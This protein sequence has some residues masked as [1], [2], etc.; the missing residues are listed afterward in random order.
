MAL[1]PFDPQ[2]ADRQ[3]A[4]TRRV[5]E[6]SGT[7]NALPPSIRN[8]Y[9]DYMTRR[10]ERGAPV[11]S[12]TESRLALQAAATGQAATPEPERDP[13]NLLGNTLANARDLASVV[14][15]LFMPTRG[16]PLY[17]EAHETFTEGPQAVGEALDQPNPFKA[18]TDLAAAPGVRLVPGAYV[19]SNLDDPAEL[20]R[21]P[22]FTALDVAPYAKRAAQATP[23][24]KAATAAYRDSLPAT[25][26]AAR[27][28]TVRALEGTGTDPAV[29]GMTPPPVFRTALTRK[30]TPTGEVVPNM[31]GRAAGRVGER[32]AE[33]G[34]GQAAAR[35]FGVGQA[36][37]A[38]RQLAG[39]ASRLDLD[40]TRLASLDPDSIARLSASTDPVQARLGGLL[41]EQRRLYDD[42]AETRGADAATLEAFQDRI[43]RGDL[44]GLTP[45]EQALASRINNLNDTY[46]SF[47]A[48]QFPERV[49]NVTDSRSLFTAPGTEALTGELLDMGKYQRVAR[50]DRKWRAAAL[51]EGELGHNLAHA[52]RAVLDDKN[53]YDIV[54]DADGNK[55]LSVT[56]TA[57]SS[58]NEV[59][60]H[61]AQLA[62]ELPGRVTKP[63]AQAY[64]DMRAFVKARDAFARAKNPEAMG[65][66]VRDMDRTLKAMRRRRGVIGGRVD[67]L[68][69]DGLAQLREARSA[70]DQARKIGTPAKAA[71]R[72]ASAE[73]RVAKEV[74]RAMP[75]RYQPVVRDQFQSE[76]VQRMERAATTD[77]DAAAGLQAARE[78]VFSGLGRWIDESTLDDLWSDLE[79]GWVELKEAGVDP[80]FVHAADDQALAALKFP[81]VAP[82]MSDPGQVRARTWDA[83]PTPGGPFVALSHQ[84]MELV[85][86]LGQ[87]ELTDTIES[88]FARKYGEQLAE[89]TARFEARGAA[90]PAQAARAWMEKHTVAWTPHGVGGR[91]AASVGDTAQL[92]VP[93]SMAQVIR[94]M[95]EPPAESLRRLADP[96]MKVFR[97]AVLPLSPRW[98][99]N[100]VLG[101]SL[102]FT[103]SEGLKGWSTLPRAMREV[104]KF[105]QTVKR[106]WHGDDAPLA[107]TVPRGAPQTRGG[108]SGFQFPE[109][110]A[111]EPATS[112]NRLVATRKH[113]GGRTL[114]HLWDQIQQ[115]KARAGR[116]PIDALY[117][118]NQWVDDIGRTM[119]SIHNYDRAVKAGRGAAE[120]ELEAAAAVRRVS[121]SWDTLLPAERQILRT[122]FPFYSFGRF[123]VGFSLRYPVDH[124][125]RAA[126]TAS[127]ARNEIEDMGTGLPDQFAGLFQLTDMDDQ[128]NAT[129]LAP[130]A[131][132]PFRDVTDWF[133]LQGFVGMTNPLVSATLQALGVEPVQ[134][135]PMLYP[136]MVYDPETGG[137]RAETPGF[138]ESLVASTVPQTQVVRNLILGN[139]EWSDLVQSNPQAAQRQLLSQLGVPTLVQDRNVPQE[140][141]RAEVNRYRS[142]RDEWNEAVRSGGTAGFAE[143][144]PVLAEYVRQYETL[145]AAAAAA[146]Q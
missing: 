23:A 142:M 34:V 76:V 144:Y 106:A 33:T 104:G 5:S 87:R 127:F 145:N 31:L 98:Q 21:N 134:G 64:T 20:A 49:V 1:P 53:V 45:D 14:P 51:A 116:H 15:K 130:G 52:R 9:L 110:L 37:R 93:S 16:N 73:R 30:T 54:R 126:V 78:G 79:R 77:P 141:F 43:V 108:M 143:R 102:I 4:A 135:G 121:Q 26:D 41:D 91:R 109:R 56:P 97:T 44:D 81:H 140:T 36:G 39:L 65:A 71:K 74:E 133:T 59:A 60:D 63:Q 50:A 115:A 8:S 11:L 38:N 138:V 67:D 89:M 100:N 139:E 57:R 83:T 18:L 19:V 55:T 17:K 13:K 62:D 114:A 72:L 40:V 58:I 119:A 69:A 68:V 92:R 10:A 29:L 90:D 85:R 137:L 112:T 28:S 101:N 124:P 24:V 22:L 111:A 95:T 6:L 82:K 66:A 12:N 132:N 146:Q 131:A 120:A 105:S 103:A 107:S 88:V 96:V 80:V 125:V 61:F 118:A 117:A 35:T 46:K 27:A 47:I 94:Q 122:V 99:V 2:A 25:L 86:D 42:F 70:V 123:I 48:E 32:L 136:N 75:A 84:A 113:T 129:F 128:G 3:K 7:L